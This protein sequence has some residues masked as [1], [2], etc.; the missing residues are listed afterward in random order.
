MYKF[1]TNDWEVLINNQFISVF[2]HMYMKVYVKEFIF[3]TSKLKLKPF[4][5]EI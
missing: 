2:V 4:C 3:N 1:I 5:W